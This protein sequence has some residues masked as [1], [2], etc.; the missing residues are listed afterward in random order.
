MRYSAI[1]SIIALGL[2]S[3]SAA[4]PLSGLVEGLA[5]TIDTVT[6]T[7][8]GAEQA[9]FYVVTTLTIRPQ[10]ALERV[11]KHLVVVVAVAP[12][13]MLSPPPQAR[14]KPVPQN[15]QVEAKV[16]EFWGFD[17][18]TTRPPKLLGASGAVDEDSQ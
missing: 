17:A 12:R 5:G 15:L 16:L 2:T 1:V 9:T 4:A 8:T 10:K 11:S 6:A 3:F 13:E 18:A 14:S 7:V